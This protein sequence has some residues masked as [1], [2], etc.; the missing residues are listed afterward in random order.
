MVQSIYKMSL[1][2]ALLLVFGTFMLNFSQ[3]G[4]I[5]GNTAVV[6]YSYWDGDGDGYGDPNTYITN[7]YRQAEGYVTN[8][9]DCD[10]TDYYK[11]PN[12]PE[13]CK[14]GVDNDCDGKLDLEEN[15]VICTKY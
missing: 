1:M 15:K 2:L 6:R 9:L 7:A 4:S 8:N 14:P 13:I 3:T 12:A 11:H 5:T 10:D